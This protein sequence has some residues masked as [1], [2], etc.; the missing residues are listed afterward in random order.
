[1][2]WKFPNFF[3][4]HYFSI[5]YA[6]K[7]ETELLYFSFQAGHFFCNVHHAWDIHILQRKLF[8]KLRVLSHVPSGKKALYHSVCDLFPSTYICVLKLIFVYLV[9]KH[10]KIFLGKIIKK[11]YVVVTTFFLTLLQVL[12]DWRT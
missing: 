1:M 3:N 2:I 6:F 11:I 8:I 12:S 7:Q 5:A 4:I 9:I 10:L